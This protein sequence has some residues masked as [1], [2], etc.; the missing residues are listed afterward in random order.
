M[1]LAGDILLLAGSPDIIDPDDP[2][3]YSEWRGKGQLLLFSA[4][5]GEKLAEVDLKAPPVWDGI[6][7][8]NGKLFLTLSNGSVECW[9]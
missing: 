9:Q 7:L 6:A 3:L 1:A 4:R 8:S 2:L 5:A